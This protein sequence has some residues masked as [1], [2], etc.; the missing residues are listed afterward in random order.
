MNG[1]M[2]VMSTCLTI[3]TKFCTENS[4]ARDSDEETD[5]DLTVAVQ[6]EKSKF[7]LYVTV[8]VHMTSSIILHP[9]VW[10]QT[11]TISHH[12]GTPILHKRY[13]YLS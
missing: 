2:T 8:L 9:C 1:V 4:R 7:L 3:N 13:I 10:W 5:E 12:F 6:N 11:H